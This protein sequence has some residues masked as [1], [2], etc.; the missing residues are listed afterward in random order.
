MEDIYFI[1]FDNGYNEETIECNTRKEAEIEIKD[2]TEN[3]ME[4]N[5]II[6]GRLLTWT[7]HTEISLGEK[8]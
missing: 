4:I 1:T 8:E 5:Q 7:V 3:G 2:L 6:K